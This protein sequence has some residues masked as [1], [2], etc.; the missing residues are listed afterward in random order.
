MEYIILG[1]KANQRQTCEKIVD[2]IFENC[3]LEMNV[4]QM[5]KCSVSQYKDIFV[6]IARLIL[7]VKTTTNLMEEKVRII[8][9]FKIQKLL[10]KLGKTDYFRL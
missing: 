6:R 7:G 1:N 8:N 10:R 9:I 5:E 3:G 2:F 4:K